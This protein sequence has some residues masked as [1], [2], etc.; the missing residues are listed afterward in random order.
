[1]A[2]LLPDQFIG[3]SSLI[4]RLPH[5]GAQ[6]TVLGK[7]PVSR[8]L[9]AVHLCRFVGRSEAKADNVVGT[10]ENRGWF[11]DTH[12]QATLVSANMPARET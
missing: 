3:R 6:A 11:S 9:G 5:G 12:W 10:P 1:M 4:T 8:P 7:T 2:E